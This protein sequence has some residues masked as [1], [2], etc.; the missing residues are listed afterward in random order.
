V[1]VKQ[2]KWAEFKIAKV[3][4]QMDYIGARKGVV[5]RQKLLKLLR[6]RQELNLMASNVLLK[7]KKR[8]HRLQLIWGVAIVTHRFRLYMIKNY[9]KMSMDDRNQFR[10]KNAITFRGIVISRAGKEEKALP[11]VKK[12]WIENSEKLRG[13]HAILNFT[14]TIREI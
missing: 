7:I 1:I 10:I 2:N 11:I 3:K 14:N 5:R 13:F 6:L 12:F 9:N 8:K 4:G